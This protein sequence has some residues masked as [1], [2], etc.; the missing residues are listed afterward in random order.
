MPPK[1]M[2]DLTKLPYPAA[3]RVLLAIDAAVKLH[4]LESI[5]FG[6]NRTG[7]VKKVIDSQIR[8]YMKI[9]RQCIAAINEMRNPAKKDLTTKG[10]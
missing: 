4:R 1:I 10:K 3:E 5:D 2:I 6:K 9:E 7:G 8:S